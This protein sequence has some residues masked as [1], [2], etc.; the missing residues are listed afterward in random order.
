METIEVWSPILAD[1][2]PFWQTAFPDM[3]LLYDDEHVKYVCMYVGYWL[4]A[5]LVAGR[6]ILYLRSKMQKN[7]VTVT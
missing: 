6:Q 7:N 3:M 2:I 4:T 5:E 1:F